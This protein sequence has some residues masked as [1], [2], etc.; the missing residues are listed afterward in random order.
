MGTLMDCRENGKNKLVVLISGSGTNLQ[1]II[2]ACASKRI[3]GYISRV[4]S[5]TRSAYGIIRAE[6]V[7][8]PTTIHLLLP[9]KR[10]EEP[11]STGIKIARYKY[12]RDLSNIIIEENPALVICAGW[13]HILSN[14]CLD[15]LEKYGIKLINLHPALPATFD[16]IHAI[17]RA[18]KAFCEG[19]IMKTGVMVHQ[20]IENIDQGTPIIVKEVPMLN[21]ETFSQF[22]ERMHK[23][24]H[25]VIVEAISIILNATNK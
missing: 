12:D 14:A 1:A 20:V 22:E 24:E 17:E 25:E 3:N 8:I 4:I 19:K 10:K 5:N 21:D 2:D 18:Y 23:I 13:M 11:N 16:G 9:Y 15:P 7:G 6:K